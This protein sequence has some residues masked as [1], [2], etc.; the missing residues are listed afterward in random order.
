VNHR[1][2]SS[3]VSGVGGEF[4]ADRF[5][6]RRIHL[7]GIGGSG[8]SGL[9]RLLRARGAVVTGT[10]ASESDVITGLIR[11]GV[12]ITR[13]AGDE[14]VTLPDRCD[15]VVA[16]AAIGHNDV[17][18]L[19]AYRANIAVVTYAEALGFAQCDRTAVCIAGTHGKST[20]TALLSHIL[21]RCGLDPSVIVGAACPQVGG[22]FRLG[23]P[24]IPAGSLAGHPGLI[25]CEACEFNR[26]FLRHNPAVAL[27][28]NVEEDHLDCYGHLGAIVE[29]FRDFARLLPE[30][31][32]G[33]RLLIAH[34]GAHRRE[35][36]ADLRCATST[37]GFSPEADFQVIFDPEARTAAVRHDGDQLAHWRVP[38]PGAHNALNSAAAGIMASWLGAEW[39]A[40]A[41]A[42]ANFEG[43]D[44]RSQRLGARVVPGGE[45]TVYDDY[46]HHP[47]EVEKTLHA[48]R[49][50]E[51]PQRLVCVFQPH[52]HSRTRFLLE[53]F[54]ESFADCDEVIVPHIHFVRDSEAERAS[55]SANDLVERLHRRHVRALHLPT[56][57][58]IVEHLDA[59]CRAGDLVVV[60][61]AGP[62]WTIARDY[63]LRGETSAIP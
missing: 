19:A 36:A 61:G 16:S 3:T 34:D 50:A 25:V 24:E 6:G 43:L 45:V 59:N 22:G 2:A 17:D 37:F 33:G 13:R 28:N 32:A 41:D 12:P 26:S 4:G 40:I 39:P 44:R 51:R 63:L 46:G 23:S 14:P 49:D 20:T 11:D 54:A 42:I 8:M 48:I 1:P 29:A 52:Q 47:T 10:D 9:A 55:V 21:I 38:L 7:I 35:I 57:E 53:Q 15:L 56:F 60:M 58:L 18:V 62:V 27:I 30:A 31:S 5:V